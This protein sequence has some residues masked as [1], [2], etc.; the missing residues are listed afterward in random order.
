MQVDSAAQAGSTI[1]RRRRRLEVLVTI[2]AI[3]VI[4]AVVALLVWVAPFAAS[5]AR[6]EPANPNTGVGFTGS[7]VIH[8]EPGNVRVHP[9]R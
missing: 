5:E 1:T 9:S 4:A 3:V 8:D 7:A 6:T 2:A